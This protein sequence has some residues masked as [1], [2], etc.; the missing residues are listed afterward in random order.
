MAN[1][2]SSTNRRQFVSAIGRVAT[3]LSLGAMPAIISARSAR[4]ADRLV[5]ASYGGTLGEFMEAELN[6]PF[7]AETGIRVELVAG[8]D[9]AKVKAQ[10]MSK[11]VEWDVIDGGGSFMAAGAKDNLWE[12]LDT[13]ILDTSRLLVPAREDRMPVFVFAGGIGYDPARSSAPPRDYTQLWDVKNHPG[14]RALRARVDGN[15]EM[16]LIA[17]GVD[18]QK[19]YPLDV[20]RAFKSLD[21]IKPHVV[22]WFTEIPQSIT[23]LQTK[24]ADFSI[25]FASR[26]KSAVDAGVPLAFSFDQTMNGLDYYAVARGSPRKEAAMQYIAFASRPERQAAYAEKLGLVPVA[27]GATE[28]VSPAARKWLPDLGNKKSV[29]LSD[30]W[31]QANFVPLDKRFREWILT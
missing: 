8:T 11:N 26:V 21:R 17:D 18:P 24:E 10:V 13:N 5:V 7:T 20:E 4:A 1:Q 27:K 23:L 25:T 12:S 6:K 16:A 9:L 22:K 3:A 14:R 19:L 30:D 2:R 28:K 15:L 29:L 31:W